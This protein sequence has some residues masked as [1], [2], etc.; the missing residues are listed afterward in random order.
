MAYKLDEINLKTVS[1]PIG[2]MEECDQLYRDR[3]EEAVDRRLENKWRSPIIL[4]SGPSG[5]GK[6]TTD[7]KI[8]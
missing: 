3:V 1:D 5:S 7:M 8:A 6:T 2:F 4:R